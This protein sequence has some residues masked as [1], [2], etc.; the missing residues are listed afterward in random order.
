AFRKSA[1][2][3][4]VSGQLTGFIKVEAV[5]F[6]AARLWLEGNPAYE[7]GGTV[8]VRELPMDA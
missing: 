2:P 8:E 3:A 6:A 7:S 1:I 4:P 5:D